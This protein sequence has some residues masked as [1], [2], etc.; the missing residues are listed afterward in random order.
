MEDPKSAN[1][2]VSREVY[3]SWG[4]LLVL[5]VPRA[6]ALYRGMKV[7]YETFLEKEVITNAGKS[8]PRP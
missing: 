5:E 6:V 8:E 2:K 1:M 3:T 7:K 4:A